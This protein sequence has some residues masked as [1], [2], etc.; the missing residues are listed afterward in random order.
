MT[1]TELFPLQGLSLNDL[2]EDSQ[3][4]IDAM[5]QRFTMR[6]VLSICGRAFHGPSYGCALV[7]G[8]LCCDRLQSRRWTVNTVN[9]H[10]DSCGV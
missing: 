4:T 3:V 1:P 9:S 2:V 8:L 5:R 6:N 10:A 7:A